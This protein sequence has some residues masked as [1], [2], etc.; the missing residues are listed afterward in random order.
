M[1]KNII[2]IF[3]A[4][5][6][7]IREEYDKVYSA[8]E[9]ENL[10]VD[11]LEFLKDHFDE[12]AELEDCFID[13]ISDRTRGPYE[14]VVFCMRELQWPKVK[15]AVIERIESTDDPR[16]HSCMNDILAVYAKEWEDS[17]LFEYYSSDG[18]GAG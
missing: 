11:F 15:E 7:A 13:L 8:S 12:Q 5:C 17:D 6:S 14:I 4:K 10:L 2:D 3:W 18:R 16:I 1:S 9:I